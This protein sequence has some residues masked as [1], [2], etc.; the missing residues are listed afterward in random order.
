MRGEGRV[1]RRRREDGRTRCLPRKSPAR[2]SERGPET[3]R[4]RTVHG[5]ARERSGREE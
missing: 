2:A 5:G 1:M 3:G 4:S